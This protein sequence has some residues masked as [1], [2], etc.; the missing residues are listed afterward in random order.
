MYMVSELLR[1][2][3]IKIFLDSSENTRRK[4]RRIQSGSNESIED[5]RNRD[6]RDTNRKISPLVIPN[7]ALVINNENMTIDEIIMLIKENLK[8]Q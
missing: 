4:R 7:E 3:Y 1:D 5:I 8:L 2:S 6:A